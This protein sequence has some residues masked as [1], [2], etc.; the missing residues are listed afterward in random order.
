MCA[1]SWP[2]PEGSESDPEFGGVGIL[3]AAEREEISRGL[4]MG[5]SARMIAVSLG[6]SPST[7]SREIAR[8]GGRNAYRAAVADQPAC[9]RARRPK[10]AMPP[11]GP[12]WRTS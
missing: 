9:Q 5:C 2:K 10:P 7:I 1:G 8:H 4:T 6:R 11:C 12:W 3:T